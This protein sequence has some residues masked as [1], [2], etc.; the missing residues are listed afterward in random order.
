MA[1]LPSPPCYQRHRPED[2]LL[3][4]TLET[5][6][7]AFLAR[8]ADQDGGH[9]LPAFVTRELRAYLRGGR[10]E[11]GCVHVRCEQCGD[12]MVVALNC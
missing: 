3:Y 4:R 6:L 1:L 11:H 2:S 5:H 9:G 8:A 10:L 12:E 7:D